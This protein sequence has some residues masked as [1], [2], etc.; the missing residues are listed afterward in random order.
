LIASRQRPRPPP[1]APTA[2]PAVLT[3][4]RGRRALAAGVFYVE[5]LN[6]PYPYSG[7]QVFEKLTDCLA[8]NEIN[9]WRAPSLVQQGETAVLQHFQTQMPYGL[10]VL[11]RTGNFA[12]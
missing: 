6:Q 12:R 11:E 7:F 3:Q 9:S 4:R 10:F 5:F 2:T 8:I 1:P